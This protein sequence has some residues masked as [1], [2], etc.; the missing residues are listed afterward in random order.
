M[1]HIVSYSGGHSSALVAI[2]VVEDIIYSLESHKNYKINK[3]LVVP[4]ESFT[5]SLSS[6]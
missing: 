3:L 5:Q 6:K 2:A 4:F 1:K